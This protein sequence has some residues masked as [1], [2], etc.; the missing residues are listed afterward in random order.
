MEKSCGSSFCFWAKLLV[1]I[2]ALPM[3]G[4]I[5]A[6]QFSDPNMRWLAFGSSMLVMV[7]LAMQVDKMPAMQKKIV[8]RD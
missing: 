6:M 4:Y 2:P 5:V 1:A 3:V 8:S 7:W